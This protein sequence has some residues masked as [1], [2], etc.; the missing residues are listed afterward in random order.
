MI[1][2]P[3]K[4]RWRVVHIWDW[5]GICLFTGHGPEDPS[6]TKDPAHRLNTAQEAAGRR[7][8]LHS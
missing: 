1:Y 7:L 5:V 2:Q 4:S 6:E 8:M 3:G